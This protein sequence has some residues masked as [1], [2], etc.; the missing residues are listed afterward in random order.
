MRVLVLGASGNTGKLVV[1]QLLDRNIETRILIR[2]NRV[3]SKEIMDSPLI[4]VIRGSIGE[5]NQKEM[6][7][8]IEDCDIVISCLGHNISF[9]G[10]FGKPHNLVVD[11]VKKVCSASKRSNK[12]MIKIIL[13][14]TTAYTNFAIGEKNSFGEKIVFSLFKWLLPPHRDNL[15]TADYLINEVSKH[16]AKIEWVAV[17]PDT[18]TH[19]DQVSPYEIHESP[20]RSPIFNAG[21]TSRINVSQFMIELTTDE[22]LWKKWSFKTPVLYNK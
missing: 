5:F 14:S 7:N 10:I 12:N 17:R 19:N 8:L 20:V 18:L 6:D 22:E 1:K 16:E 9:K 4:D 3:I 11:A 15:K 2:E 13:M 21:K